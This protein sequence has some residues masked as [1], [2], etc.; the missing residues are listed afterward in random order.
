[1]LQI[2]KCNQKMNRINDAD[3]WYHEAKNNKANFT[4]QDSYDF[5][6]ILMGQQ[7]REEAE[8]VLQN[9]IVEK[10]GDLY[11][12]RILNDLLTV[13]KYYKDSLAYQRLGAIVSIHQHQ[14]LD[15]PITKMALYF[16]PLRRKA[17][18]RKNPPGTTVTS[19]IFIKAQRHQINNFKSRL[20]WRKS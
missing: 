6:Y 13:E 19:S 10:P 7:K 11:A 17:R 3:K 5:V 14:S 16:L 8:S 2:A 15:Q 20:C 9:L 1:M 4:S 12:K 18:R